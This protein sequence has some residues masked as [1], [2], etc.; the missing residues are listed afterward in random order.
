MLGGR[1][2]LVGQQLPGRVGRDA[3]AQAED[4]LLLLDLLAAEEPGGGQGEEKALEPVRP[5]SWGGEPSVK[6]LPPASPD[7]ELKSRAAWRPRVRKACGMGA[8]AAPPS[9]RISC[10]ALL[11]A[12]FSASTSP[13]RPLPAGGPR[14]QGALMVETQGAQPCGRR[15]PAPCRHRLGCLGASEGPRCGP[16][17][18]R[19]SPETAGGPM[20][21]G[22]GRA[23]SGPQ[24]RR[25]RK[26][27]WLTLP[28]EAWGGLAAVR[29]RG[30]FTVAS[31]P[32]QGC[33]SSMDSR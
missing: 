12:S 9:F 24:S 19:L 22:V 13:R 32:T 31:A 23:V 7:P 17:P 18:R 29:D 10:V 26:T 30:L 1:Q 6:N 15:A 20:R 21:S 28:R 5:S 2:A 11:P 3:D 25:R 33:H 14:S 8:Q 27:E 4:A 16:T